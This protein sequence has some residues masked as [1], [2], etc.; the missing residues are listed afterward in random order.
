M[1]LYCGPCVF[2]SANVNVVIGEPV[3]ALAGAPEL[4]PAAV[5]ALLV[6]GLLL[7]ALLLVAE[8]EF[9]LLPQADR[10]SAAT[11]MT[12]TTAPYDRDRRFG[13]PT[14]LCDGICQTSCGLSADNPSAR[15]WE[16]G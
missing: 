13:T 9:E 7:A 6:A 4:V 3:A 11:N 1:F 12:A 14:L 2:T 8:L 16:Y 15:Q 5:L 10:T